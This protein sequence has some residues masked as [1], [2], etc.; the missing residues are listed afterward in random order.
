MHLPFPLRNG[1]LSRQ[2]VSCSSP[3]GMLFTATGSKPVTVHKTPNRGHVQEV[4]GGMLGSLLCLLNDSCCTARYI[5]VF[6][7]T[8]SAAACRGRLC[9][10]V[11]RVA[12]YASFL[13]FCGIP[14]GYL[15]VALQLWD[16]RR[17]HRITTCC[18][19]K[20]SRDR[21]PWKQSSNS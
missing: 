14:S 16:C 5:A 8:C 4:P 7:T 15:Y 19:K 1:R 21:R 12:P 9:S 6:G 11:H 10:H 2:R 18:T 20:S 3:H 17:R 13:L